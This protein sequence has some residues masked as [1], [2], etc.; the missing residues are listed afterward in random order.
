LFP[1]CWWLRHAAARKLLSDAGFPNGL[2]FTFNTSVGAS[3]AATYERETTVILEQ[4]KKIGISG[5][6]QTPDYPTYLQNE[7][8]GLF[9]LLPRYFCSTAS[10][11]GD[12]EYSLL[13]YVKGGTCN[14]MG[15]FDQRV[16]DL[17][18]RQ[19]GTADIAAR[20]QTVQA[21]NRL[22]V[23]DLAWVFPIYTELFFG[24]FRPEVKGYPGEPATMATDARNIFRYERVWLDTK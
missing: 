22:V 4:L 13:Y 10:G 15:W 23:N 16:E 11:S 3:A 21:I 7:A 14:V 24:G 2:N 12:P 19:L 5:T 20:L 9:Q 18:Q 1:R 8:K 6:I 17:Y